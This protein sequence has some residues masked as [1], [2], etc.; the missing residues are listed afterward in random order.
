MLLKQIYKFLVFYSKRR[1]KA[2]YVLRNNILRDDMTGGQAETKKGGVKY[3]I[4]ERDKITSRG[5]LAP[6]NHILVNL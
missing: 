1:E 6:E 3:E 4:G 5:R 2:L